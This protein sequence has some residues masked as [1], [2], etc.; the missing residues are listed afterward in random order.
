MREERRGGE[1]RRISVMAPHYD[2]TRN[3]QLG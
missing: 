1:E 3:T 2:N